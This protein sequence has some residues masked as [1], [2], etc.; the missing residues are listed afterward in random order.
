M[1]WK[2]IQ[3]EQIVNKCPWISTGQSLAVPCSVWIVWYIILH[4]SAPKY[5]MSFSIQM[6]HPAGSM[7]Y[8]IIITGSSAVSR[9]CMA[10]S[11]VGAA[12]SC[13][14]SE[15]QNELAWLQNSCFIELNHQFNYSTCLFFVYSFLLA[16]WFVLNSFVFVMLI[17]SATRFAADIKNNPW[18]GS[19]RHYYVRIC[20]DT[21]GQ[22][23][24]GYVYTI[25]TVN[26]RRGGKNTIQVIKYNGFICRQAVYLQHIFGQSEER[27]SIVLNK[28]RRPK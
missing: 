12:P 27:Y 15:W 8:D 20:N 1:W 10:F 23:Y 19:S 5:S 13:L 26:L 11:F 16:W 25:A 28:G 2:D 24:T 6:W 4:T 14:G 9:G 7:Q 18:E 17:S 3:C 22:S 21:I